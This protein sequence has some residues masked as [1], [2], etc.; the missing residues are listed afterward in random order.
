MSRPSVVIAC[1]ALACGGQAR[2]DGSAGAT[3]TGGAGG[4]PP[5]GG[6]GGVAGSPSGGAAGASCSLPPYDCVPAICSGDVVSLPVCEDG[7]WGACPDGY[8]HP[9]QCPDDACFHPPIIKCCDSQGTSS[10][11]TCPGQA[12]EVCPPDTYMSFGTPC[13]PAGTF[14]CGESGLACKL[15]QEFCWRVSAG[16]ASCKPLPTTCGSAPDCACLTQV[17]CSQCHDA[18]LDALTVYCN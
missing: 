15:G 1:I 17:S 13:P 4:S 12:G 3:S 2:H 6:A 14:P 11:P 18:G 16:S 5:A 8:V 10:K 7:A 9:S